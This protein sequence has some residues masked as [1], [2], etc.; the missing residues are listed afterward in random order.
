MEIILIALSG[1]MQFHRAMLLKLWS[2]ARSR[3]QRFGY[4]A[5]E[6]LMLYRRFRTI[7]EYGTEFLLTLS[8][9]ILMGTFFN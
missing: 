8:L 9:K 5:P 2:V 4:Q 3:Y 7:R 1:Q 6:I